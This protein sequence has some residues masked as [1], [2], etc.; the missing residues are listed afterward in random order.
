MNTSPTLQ[1]PLP[2]LSIHLKCLGSFDS[3]AN[4]VLTIILKLWEESSGLIMKEMSLFHLVF[5]TVR[6][7]RIIALKHNY[8]TTVPASVIRKWNILKG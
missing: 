7:D 8:S 1:L 2:N 3:E 4:P 5:G 6:S